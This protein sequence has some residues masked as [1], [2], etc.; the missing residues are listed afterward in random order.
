MF[1]FNDMS[2]RNKLFTLV[3]VFVLGTVIIGAMAFITLRT[4]DID[5][6]LSRSI[7]LRYQVMTDYPPPRGSLLVA[8]FLIYRMIASHSSDDIRDYM[9]KCEAALKD[10]ETYKNS[11]LTNMAEGELKD[12]LK[13]TF[14]TGDQFVS[15][16]K[17]Q[18]LPLVG[19]GKMDQA[20]ELRHEKLV[21]L[22]KVYEKT[23]DEFGSLAQRQMEEAKQAA[24]ATV[25]WRTA[26]MIGVLVLCIVTGTT[27][28]LI[29]E[30]G[31]TGR[32]QEKLEVLKRVAAGD[33]SG[34]LKVMS[35]DEI[36]QLADT[37]NQMSER[38]SAMVEEIRA[39]SETLSSASEELTASAQ[40]MGAQSHQASAQAGT[41]SAAAE[42]LSNNVQTV[43]TATEEMTV[44]IKEI[45]KNATEAAQVAD[46]AARVA[47]N[48]NATV[49]KLGE[50]SAEIGNVIK[51]IT[52]IAEQTN[53]LALNATIEAARA[54]EAG[55]G[56]AVVANEV[57]ELAKETAKATEDIGRKVEAIQ[58]DAKGAVDTIGQITG[59]IKRIN[60][61]QNTIASAVEEQTATTNEIARNISEGA[62]G[63]TDI[64]QNIVGVA[65]A[66]KSTE[67]SASAS[68]QAA[69]ELA[70]MAT[71][72]RQ[73]VERFKLIDGEHAI[74]Q[75]RP[76]SAW[77]AA[78]ERYP[79]RARA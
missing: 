74:S 46:S 18:I 5:S 76:A 15:I 16:T 31:L 13:K 4:V 21:P 51:V 68:Q 36:G 40:Q 33:L 57:K 70:K 61:I 8:N 62:K 59:V 49:S 58:G 47:E 54:G 66:A 65:Q 23:I 79:E 11:Y 3:G 25:Q 22:Y 29:I 77:S 24:R 55:K 43:S 19:S 41:V 35:K 7:D 69:A 6:D 14:E 64:A 48:T 72:L 38:L 9:I 50:S 71:A 32:L 75:S 26:A 78:E 39:N 53:L 27:I 52:S 1:G 10:Y 44:S 73:L 42:Q 60:D 28:A 34:R 67:E 2:V 63:S 37:I 12:L 30:R 17:N 45:A 20:N 56:F